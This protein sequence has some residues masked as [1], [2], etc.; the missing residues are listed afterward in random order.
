MRAWIPLT[1]LLWAL[2]ACGTDT[3]SDPAD[4]VASND[5]DAAADTSA[6]A[7][8]AADASGSAP[9]PFKVRG[10]LE[11]VYVWMAPPETAMELVDSDGGVIAEGLSDSYGG[12]VWRELAPTADLT[13]RVK[14]DPALSVSGI[15]VKSEAQ[16]P[17]DPDLYAAQDL[18]PGNNYIETRDGTLLHVFVSL[19]GPV[20][21]GPYPTI[22]NYSGYSPGQPGQKLSDLVEPFCASFPVLCDAPNHGAGLFAGL[23]GYASVGVNMRGTGC[24]GGA[25]DYFEPLQLMDGYDVV[26]VVARQTWVKHNKVGMGGLSYPGISQLFVAKT[27]PPSLAAITPMSVLADSASSTLAP[28]GIFNDG[29]ALAWIENVL[30][31][32]RPY[33]HGWIQDVIDGGDA[34]CEEHQ[35]LHDQMVDV[36]AKA[37]VNP[38]YTDEVAQPLDPS[39]WADRIDIPVFLTGQWHDEQ[40]GPHFAAL[41]DKF[42]S[43]PSLRF[44]VTNGVH[45]D[46]FTP[47][48]LMEWKTFL[49]LYV[50]REVPSIDEEL[51]PLVPLFYASFAGAA[52]ELPPNRFA[53]YTDYDTARSD[54]EAEPVLRVIWENGGKP[55]SPGAPE[56]VFE[57]HHDA[58]PVPETEARR[59]YFQPDGGL[60]A[61]APTASEGGSSFNHDPDAWDRTTLPT[62]SIEDL[63]PPW[64]YRPL[65]EGKAVAFISAPLDEDLV[66]LGHGSV[67]LWLKSTAEDADLEVHLTEVRP[68]GEEM[69]VQSGWLRASHRALREDATELRPVKHHT[70]E[71]YELLTPGQWH[72]VRVEIMPFGHIFRAG[73]QIR[74]SVDTPG[75]SAARWFFILLD[76]DAEVVHTVGH[77]ATQASSVVLPVIPSIA[78][79]TDRPACNALRGQPCRTYTPLVN[80]AAP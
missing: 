41:L 14:D 9:P 50:A 46:G 35:G 74:L 55:D 68:D 76:Q 59:W 26:E 42:T 51:V 3:V 31:R 67:D 10:T 22:V 16:L 72:E 11:Q 1:G 39:A 70:E 53:D 13:V 38:F 75:D 23:M 32:A 8:D 69:L 56:G 54:Y 64:D 44:T 45:V 25:Y 71:A 78:V 43:S 52:L 37:L 29:F 18:K 30:E 57:T 40:T 15:S 19:P 36:V 6:D 12:L 5:V 73:S 62:G 17:P 60:S 34:L 47:Q 49:D 77:N 66:M 65:I 21:D 7:A 58:W 63:A 48:I 33:G 4:V 79:T 61:T 80:T 27:Q 24:S 20:E 2:S 28:G